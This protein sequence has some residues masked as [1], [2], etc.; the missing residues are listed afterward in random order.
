MSAVD[1]IAWYRKKK[2]LV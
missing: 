2:T 1:L